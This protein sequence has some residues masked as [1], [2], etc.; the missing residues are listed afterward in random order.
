[1][2]K[3][4]IISGKVAM[5]NSIVDWPNANYPGT[6]LTILRTIFN[7][8]YEKSTVQLDGEDG[9]IFGTSSCPFPE[10]V[11]FYTKVLS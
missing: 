7:I 6:H 8:D 3:I 9:P 4:L 5:N 10:N 1:M 11:G 2:N